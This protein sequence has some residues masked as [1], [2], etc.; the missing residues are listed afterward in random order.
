MRRRQCADLTRLIELDKATEKLLASDHASLDQLFVALV[1]AIDE[2]DSV[3]SLSRLDLLW[4]R[5]GMHI[6]AEHLWLFP[7]ILDALDGAHGDHTTTLDKDVVRDTIEGLKGDHNFF[8]HEFARAINILRPIRLTNKE[9]ANGW[10]ETVRKI[11]LAIRQRLKAH[12][13]VE[14]ENV[15]RWASLLLIGPNQAR[16][17]SLV[18][19]ELENLPPRF[20]V[21]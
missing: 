9:S 1:L 4:A 11:V 5:L 3:E 16:L 6:R 2:N 17:A 13:E 10:Q 8:M 21:N 20:R 7:S 19:N 15:Y 12:N 18:K 14:E